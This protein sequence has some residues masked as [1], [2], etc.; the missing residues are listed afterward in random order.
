VISIQHCSRWYGQ[1]MGIIDV[2]A[3]IGAG[4]TALLGQNGAG[5]STLMRLI[6]GMIHPSTGQ[7][8]VFGEDPFANPHVNAKLG[9]C[10]EVDALPDHLSGRAF[11]MRMAGLNG[12]T[13]EEA[14]GRVQEVLELV[15]MADR[16]GVRLKGGSKG[17]RQRIKLASALIHQP[18]LVL[19]DEPLNGLDPVGRREFMELLQMLAGQGKAIVVSSHILFEVEQ[20]TRSVILLHQGRL[21]AQ[22]DLGSIRSLIDRHPHRIQI[23][24]RD[25]RRL[26]AAMAADDS[27]V[28]LEISRDEQGIELRTREPE[29]IYRSLPVLNGELDLGI[30]S[31]SSPDNSLEAVFDYLVNR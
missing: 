18:D 1:V 12:I 26:A 7:V 28:S 8:R 14:K 31:Y 22:G 5:K 20:M 2:N 30:T 21:L 3:E 13:G 11:L 17:M 24:C 29:R 15:G 9:F 27:V 25:P 6:T 23:R 10:P 4:V 19:L 16:A